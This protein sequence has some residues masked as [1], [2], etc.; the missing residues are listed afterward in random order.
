MGRTTLHPIMSEPPYRIVLVEDNKA[1]SFLLKKALEEAELR[2]ELDV[3]DDGGLALELFRRLDADSSLKA[4][5][6]VILD[7]NLPKYGG[8]EVLSR[9]RESTTCRDIP[10][11]ITTSSATVHERKQTEDL[12]V[13]QYIIKPAELEEFLQIG[14]T[15]KQLLE[16]RSRAKKRSSSGAL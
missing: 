14:R 9:L 16:R 1:D 5:D 15:I 8:V 4:P 3:L 7:L 10:V 6:L 13:E 2:F 11:I 12:D